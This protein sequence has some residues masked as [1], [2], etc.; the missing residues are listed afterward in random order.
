MFVSSPHMQPISS[1]DAEEAD[2]VLVDV[3]APSFLFPASAKHTEVV[4]ECTA[5]L[6][7]ANNSQIK[8][9]YLIGKKRKEKKKI[10]SFFVHFLLADTETR[11]QQNHRMAVLVEDTKFSISYVEDLAN[12][13]D[14]LRGRLSESLDAFST[15][16][17]AL[18]AA[19]FDLTQEKTR[20][21]M[22]EQ[23]VKELEKQI[24]QQKR[25][26]V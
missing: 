15:T 17:S 20:R 7:L 9:Y 14:I 2:L 1:S 25:G 16:Y 5:R 18:Q 12:S 24:A 13:N 21:K 26:T 22:A 6:K 19:K 23:K 11:E 10:L 3:L 4:K 8:L